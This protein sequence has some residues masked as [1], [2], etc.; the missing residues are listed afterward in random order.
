MI[1]VS[2]RSLFSSYVCNLYNLNITKNVE[3]ASFNGTH[4][5]G[6]ND[7]H[8]EQIQ[9]QNGTMLYIPN[10]IGKFFK[11][12]KKLMVGD[13][14]SLTF[15]GTKAFTRLNFKNLTKLQEISFVSNDIRKLDKDAL[16]GL[17][18]LEVFTLTAQNLNF[19]NVRTFE[20]NTKLKRVAVCSTELRLLYENVFRYNFL[21]ES[22]SFDNNVI[23]TLNEG[24]FQ[25]NANLRT[26]SLRSNKLESLPAELFKNN[27]LLFDVDFGD[28]FLANVKT[29]FTKMM[30]IQQINFD[31]NSCID[32]TYEKIRSHRHVRGLIFE[33]LTQFQNEIKKKC[34]SSPETFQTDSFDVQGGQGVQGW[35]TELLNY[36]NRS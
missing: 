33:N 14:P 17:E 15:L 32:A 5:P 24:T 26:V 10:G 19:L 29:N 30:N 25:R 6:K 21:L 8:V 36:F 7:S 11:N 22:V 16:W 23:E 20:R 18:N 4:L 2:S 9:F 13:V 31:D 34:S 35:T 28:N 1:K 27:P 3:I 12:L